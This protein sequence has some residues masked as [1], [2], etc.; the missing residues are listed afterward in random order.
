VG[1]SCG[2]AA[3]ICAW[4]VLFGP[5]TSAAQTQP[6]TA[7]AT[8]VDR[9]GLTLATADLREQPDQVL[10]SLTFPR[11]GALVGDHAIHIHE[12]SGCT[13]PDFAD[14]G[15][16]FNPRG[17]QHGFLNPAGPMVGDLPDLVLGGDGAARYNISAP[18]A[19]LRPSPTSLLSPGGTALVIADGPDDNRTQPDGNSG[20]RVAC[21]A[22][23][24]PGQAPPATSSSGGGLGSVAIGALGALLIVVGILLRSTRVR[25]T[26]VG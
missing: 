21:G 10:I 20:A 26:R 24:A 5:A 25:Q 15:G 4:A 17:N 19:T 6:T 12:H 23:L 13:A 1:Q 16:I 14:A 9:N 3:L 2:L 18:L 22:I 8:L 11:V 7:S